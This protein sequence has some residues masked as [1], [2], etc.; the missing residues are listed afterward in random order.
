MQA[1]CSTSKNMKDV[2]ARVFAAMQNLDITAL[3]TFP[4]HEIRPVLPSLVRMSLLAPLDNTTS[5]MESRKQILS[6]LIGIEVVNSIVSYLQVNYH[7]LEQELKRELQV[8]QKTP[9]EPNQQQQQFL[10]YGL[11]NGIAL[12]FERADVSRKV[13]VVLSEIFNIQWQL[14][15]N[16]DQ[17][18]F[19]EPEILDDGIYLEEVVDII[20]IALAELPTLLNILELTDALVHVHNGQRVI[21][22]LV[23]NFPDCYREVGIFAFCYIKKTV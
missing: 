18:N 14:N 12:G 17:K 20:T 1:S 4:Q 6:V 8:R 10:E 13:R 7:D 2:T 16:A 21:C 5:S 3:A 9:Y 22:T 23:A 11:H 19:L 15:A